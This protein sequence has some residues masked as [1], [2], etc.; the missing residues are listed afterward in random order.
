MLPDYQAYIETLIQKGAAVAVR[1]LAD[2]R[3]AAIAATA[4]NA[5]PMPSQQSGNFD[6]AGN[7]YDHFRYDQSVFGGADLLAP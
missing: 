4:A 6:D 5:P 1:R 3:Y 2:A 7:A